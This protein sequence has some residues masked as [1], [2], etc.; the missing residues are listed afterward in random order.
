MTPRFWVNSH[1]QKQATS[2]LRHSV[3]H[4]CAYS[5]C[6]GQSGIQCVCVFKAPR[7]YTPVL[8]TRELGS[9]LVQAGGKSGSEFRY[10]QELIDRKNGKFLRDKAGDDDDKY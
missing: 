7:T 2:E 10:P 1:L 9:K 8:G 4:Q 5:Q 6:G 3:E